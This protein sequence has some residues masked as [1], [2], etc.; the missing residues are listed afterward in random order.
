M[1]ISNLKKIA[2]FPIMDSI[3]T[4]F[5]LIKI[6]DDSTNDCIMQSSSVE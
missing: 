4:E 3:C 2:V 1:S 5:I 6:S